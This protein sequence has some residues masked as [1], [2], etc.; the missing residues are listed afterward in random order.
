[1]L[2]MGFGASVAAALDVLD[3]RKVLH[4]VLIIDLYI[5]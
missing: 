2:I 3:S 4:V 5:A 1:M